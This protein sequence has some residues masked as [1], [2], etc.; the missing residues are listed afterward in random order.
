MDTIA[1]FVDGDNISPRDMPCVMDEIKSFGRVVSSR[2]YTDWSAE[3]SK[4]WKKI[5]I[6]LALEPIQCDRVSGKNST[7]IKLTVDLMKMLY[8]IP[9]I[10]LFCLVTSDGDYRHLIPE[11]KLVNKR[12]CVI[13]S[14]ISKSLQSCCDLST[15]IEVLRMGKDINNQKHINP[16]A[17]QLQ[18]VIDQLLDEESMVQ[19]SIVRDALH[20][21][22]GFD[23]RE[24]GFNRFSKF[25]KNYLSDQYVI[26]YI[27]SACFVA[28][29]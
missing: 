29:K 22:Y 11:I 20:R 3:D 17:N 19:L 15:K 6:E 27:D 9:N 13:G 21:K 2:I 10:N 16:V 23:H 5:S 1:V 28:S 12:V 14:N 25:V 18:T 26:R 4:S 8:T 24:Y 7:D